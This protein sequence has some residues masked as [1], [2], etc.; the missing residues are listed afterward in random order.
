MGQR[1]L[2]DTIHPHDLTAE[3]LARSIAERVA[4]RE[5]PDPSRVPR[6]DGASQ[7]AAMMLEPAGAAP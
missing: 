6:L 4:Q 5:L 7:A 1:G 3:D 2:F